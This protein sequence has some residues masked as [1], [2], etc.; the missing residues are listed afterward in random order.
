MTAKTLAK[1]SSTV[2]VCLNSATSWLYWASILKAYRNEINGT[3]A[4][5]IKECHLFQTASKSVK[6]FSLF[7][8]V[9][10]FL[11]TVCSYLM[12][13]ACSRRSDR[14]YGAK[15]KKKKKKESNSDWNRLWWSRQFEQQSELSPFVSLT[16]QHFPYNWQTSFQ[17][18]GKS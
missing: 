1:N 11:F 18:L 12:K 3:R 5:P 4:S 9:E 14:K 10:P 8:L 7:Y 2:T 6:L 13:L 16:V 15:R 17:M